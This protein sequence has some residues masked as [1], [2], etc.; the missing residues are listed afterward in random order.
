LSFAS[1]IQA[2]TKKTAPKK[3]SA[4][5]KKAVSRFHSSLFPSDMLICDRTEFEIFALLNFNLCAQKIVYR[6]EKGI[7][8]ACAKKT[9]AKKATT[10]KSATKKPAAKMAKK[11]SK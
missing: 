7:Q 5:K 1:N 10:K 11:V 3:K 2:A 6:G 9:V 8:G 4:P